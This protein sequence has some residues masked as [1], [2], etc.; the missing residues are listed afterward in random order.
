MWLSY[1]CIPK[2]RELWAGLLRFPRSY[3]SFELS[4]FAKN[5]WHSGQ[6]QHSVDTRVWNNFPKAFCEQNH[7]SDFQIFFAEKKRSM[8]IFKLHNFFV[9]KDFSDRKKV[10]KSL[11]ANSF[12]SPQNY[13]I[14]I[15]FLSGILRLKKSKKICLKNML[16]FESRPPGGMREKPRRI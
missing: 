10:L 9:L 14:N 1:L 5:I 7:R 11:E 6:Y 8:Q 16:C 2:I 12:I 4:D 13:V 15:I 3:P